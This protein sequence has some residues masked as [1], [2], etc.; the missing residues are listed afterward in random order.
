MNNNRA[1]CHS[2]NDDTAIQISLK[3]IL[4]MAIKINTIIKK[5]NSQYPFIN[6]VKLLS[7]NDF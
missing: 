1:N 2:L 4:K 6:V 7:I 5:N 3:D